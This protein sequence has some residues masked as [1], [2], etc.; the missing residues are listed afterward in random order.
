MKSAVNVR[1]FTNY[2]TFLVS[3]IQEMRTK[4]PRWSYGAWAN[5]LGLKDPSSITKIV[6]GQREAGPEITEK[7][8]QYFEFTEKQSQYF[9]DLVRLEKIRRDPRLSV[10]LMEKMGKEH[11]NAAVRILDDKAFSV[12]SSWYC[13][14]LREALRSRGEGAGQEPEA[15]AKKF[16]FK[17]TPRELRQAIQSMLALGLLK[18]D[19]DGRLEIAEGC[20]DT[21]E[22][23]SSEAIKRF[24]EQMLSHAQSALRSVPAEDREITATTLLMS[25]KNMP[26]AKQL[27]RDFKHNLERLLEEDSGDKVYQF[28]IQLFPLTKNLISEETK[29]EVTQ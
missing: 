5:R 15:L 2:R 23:V 11:P 21:T 20:L 3:H 14:P 9:R 22:D 16:L 12:I 1:Q 4:N 26:R 27:I 6:Q 28:Q 24:H 7:F 18:R 10:L 29:P 25:S 13:L 17:V 19:A 8:I